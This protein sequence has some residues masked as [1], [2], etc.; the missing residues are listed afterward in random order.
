MLF[1]SFFVFCVVVCCFMLFRDCMCSVVC[2]VFCAL[3]LSKPS[4]FPICRWRR[5]GGLL[6]GFNMLVGQLSVNLPD[7]ASVN[8]FLSSVLDTPEML[9]TTFYMALQT[10]QYFVYSP[11]WGCL[12]ACLPACLY[13]LT[14]PLH[15]LYTPLHS[16]LQTL[17]FRDAK[18]SE[19][20]TYRFLHAH[21][22]AFPVHG[23]V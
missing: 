16:T 22:Y 4:R 10:T 14:F 12:S 5:Q 1:V 2:F 7:T 13:S 23:T 18:F 21:P 11:F 19:C 15:Y 17:L 20:V 8:N 9:W 3:C 6:A